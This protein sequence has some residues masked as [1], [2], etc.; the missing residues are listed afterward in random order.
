M[1][2]SP[3][4][5]LVLEGGADIADEA[6]NHLVGDREYPV[7]QRLGLIVAPGIGV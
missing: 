3:G 2:G 7:R 4:V 1:A 6:L 5:E